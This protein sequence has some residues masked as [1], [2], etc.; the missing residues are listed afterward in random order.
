MALEGMYKIYTLR[1]NIRKYA[2]IIHFIIKHYFKLIVIC[3]KENDFQLLISQTSVLEA[4]RDDR[5]VL[6]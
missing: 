3:K 2:S 6:V 4:N 1:Q 5:G